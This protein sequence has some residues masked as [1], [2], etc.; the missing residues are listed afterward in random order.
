MLHLARRYLASTHKRVLRGS[1]M[2]RTCA[3]P[4]SSFFQV[5]MKPV[6]VFKAKKKH[7]ISQMSRNKTKSPL[8]SLK[9]FFRRH[10]DPI[11]E[12]R[13]FVIRM[14]ISYLLYP[15]LSGCIQARF[16]KKNWNCIHLTFLSFSAIRGQTKNASSSKHDSWQPNL[17]INLTRPLRIAIATQIC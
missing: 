2:C 6:R 5:D 17:I 12:F 13:K 3:P 8:L 15:V 16:E 11:K 7:K 4:I 14:N 9:S 1:F 10:K